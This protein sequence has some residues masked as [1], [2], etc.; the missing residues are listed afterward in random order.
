MKELKEELSKKIN[1]S[2]EELETVNEDS[3]EHGKGYRKSG[4][5]NH[6]VLG[7]MW[8]IDI[9]YNPD[10]EVISIQLGVKK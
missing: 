2:V 3:L 6:K 7:S 9:A 5:Y 10:R 4:L 8:G 1:C